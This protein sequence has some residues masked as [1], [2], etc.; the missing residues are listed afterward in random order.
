M[1]KKHAGIAFNLI[2]GQKLEGLSTNEKIKYIIKE[3]KKEK[4]LVLENGLTP[5]EQTALIE[6]TMSKIDHDTCLV[7]VAKW[8]N[9]IEED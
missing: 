8:K 6:Q 5:I 1:R 7:F 4:I 3:I 2:S 9:R